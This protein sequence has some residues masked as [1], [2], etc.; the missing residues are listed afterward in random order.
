MRDA[1]AFQ[2]KLGIEHEIFCKISFEQ[3]CD[4]PI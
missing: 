2:I 4:I 1:K 3:L